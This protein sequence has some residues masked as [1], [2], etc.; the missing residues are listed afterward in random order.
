MWDLGDPIFN[1]PEVSLPIRNSISLTAQTFALLTL[2]LAIGGCG[3]GVPS[4][5]SQTT[6]EVLYIWDTNGEILSYTIDTGT[7]AVQA[8]GATP[9]SDSVV[10]LRADP[11]GRFL[12]ASDFNYNSIYAYS[13]DAHTG[14]LT[15]ING[16]P[17]P[18]PGG[19][20]NG[21]PLAIDPGS[22]FLFYSSAHGEIVTFL[23][24]QATGALTLSPTVPQQDDYAPVD[25]VVH[26]SGKFLY[27]SNDGNS[28][29]GDFSVFAI[30]ATTGTLTPVVGSP[31]T[32]L[33]NSE[34]FGIAVH[35]SGKYLYSPLANSRGVEGISIDNSTG[36]LTAIQGSPF[37]N[38]S[39]I[40]ESAALDPLGKYLY[41]GNLAPGSVSAYTIDAST[42]ALTQIPAPPPTDP[43][44]PGP[45]V[46]AMAVDPSGKFLFASGNGI[47]GEIQP[48]SID[49]T[50][51]MLT[52]GTLI[53]LP[54]QTFT[55]TLAILPLE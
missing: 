44:F 10:D 19:N 37:V 51:G 55:R 2:I 28:S 9:L 35:G 24:D 29:G 6:T 39:F 15:P 18:F 3:A 21:G 46:H 20:D 23:I 4:M 13:I 17:F 25:M 22:R 53:T 47:D 42:G 16:S 38:Q 7:G 26:P 36:A 54:A 5:S 30:D 12:Y 32:F 11:K 27:A 33:P 43:V 8:L 45:G 31:F 48:Y 52:R 40:A 14:A 1:T 49:P 50:S 41:V 34:P